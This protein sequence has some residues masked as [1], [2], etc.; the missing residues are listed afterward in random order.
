[1]PPRF[2]LHPWDPDTLYTTT[3]Q[4]QEEGD[5]NLDLEFEVGESDWRPLTPVGGAPRTVHFVDGAC[6]HDA[7]GTFGER[8]C[9]FAVVGVGS[10]TSRLGTRVTPPTQPPARRYVIV[11]GEDAEGFEPIRIDKYG[12]SYEPRRVDGGE[13]HLAAEAQKLMLMWEAAHAEELASKN[14]GD[15]VLVDGPLRRADSF[16]NV[17]GYVKTSERERLPGAQR[18]VLAELQPG[19]RTPIYH[20]YAGDRSL[21]DRLE[22]VI[23]PRQSAPGIDPRLGLVR[24]QANSSLTREEARALADWS[25]Q[26][27]PAYSADYHHDSRAPQQLLIIKNLESDL[28]RSFG[29][30]DLLLGELRQLLATA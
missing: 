4:G 14:P 25:A 12:L 28:R 15:L 9:L 5:E 23:R 17:L 29:N 18:G 16:Q 7:A 19:Q 22:W 13:H 27:L 21:V 6:R 3:E 30:R 8:P 24:I 10:V 1:M 20:V 11:A 2:Q 26:T